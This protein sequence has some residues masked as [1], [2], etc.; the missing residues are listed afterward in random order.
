MAEIKIDQ[1]TLDSVKG[2]VIVV[3]GQFCPGFCTGRE[4]SQTKDSQAELRESGRQRSRSCTKG[5]PMSSLETGTTRK[6]RS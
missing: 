4:E 5:V 2:K 3:T 6:A 1:N